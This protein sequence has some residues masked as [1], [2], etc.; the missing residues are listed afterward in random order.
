MPRPGRPLADLPPLPPGYALQG[1]QPAAP[2]AAALP[3]LPPGYQLQQPAPTPAKPPVKPQ[4]PSTAEEPQ[5]FADLFKAGAKAWGEGV[6]APLEAAAATVTGAVAKPVADIAG[7]AA[8]GVDLARGNKDGDPA[9]FQREVQERLTYAPRTDLGKATTE[10]IGQ[11]GD[12]TIGAAGRFSK[13]Y[14]GG[15]ARLL[16]APEA[17]SEAIGNAAEEATK[18][19]PNILGARVAGE[20]GAARAGAKAAAGP[21]G[22]AQAA[23]KAESYVRTRVG[24]DWNQ[25]PKA[26][27]DELTRIAKSSGD[28]EKLDPKAIERRAALQGLRIPVETTRAKLTRDAADLRREAVASKTDAGAPIRETDA[29]A[30]RDIQA[31]LEVLRG[32]KAGLRGGL[33]DPSEEGAP[34]TPSVRAPTKGTEDVGGSLQGSLRAKAAASKKNYDALYKKA[35]ETEP[36]ARGSVKPLDELLTRNPEIQHLGWVQGWLSKAAKAKQLATGAPEVTRL[37]DAS[38]AELHD[39]RS[40]ANEIAATGGKEGYY[41]KKVV[42]TIDGI[43]EQA[44]PAGA[45]AWKQANKAYRAHMEEFKDQGIIKKLVTNK[46]GDRALALEKTAQTI[47]KGSLEQIRQVKQSLL[48]AGEGKARFE[49]RQAW[50]DLQ[51][52]TVNRILEDARNVVATDET[53]RSVLTAAALRKGINSVG[54][55][56]L[57]EIIGKRSTDELYRILRAAKITRTEPAGRVTESGTVPNALVLAEKGL[58]HLIPGGKY[59]RG[60][61]EAIKTLGERGQAARDT[62]AAIKS[63]LQAAAEEAE[64]RAASRN[65]ARR[66]QLTTLGA[67]AGVTPREQ[68]PP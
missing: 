12:A 56:R 57:T 33:H 24:L 62:E 29:R 34:S 4:A 1:M 10:T 19:A 50:K 28:L 36:D 45:S 17:V 60:A 8:T 31:N 32:R 64:A 66:R 25:V 67:A 37:E 16:H 2:Q 44:T 7:L 48:T 26:L 58:A 52:E 5:T 14:Y 38:L 27:Q 47:A 42:K 55:D 40:D 59:I 35:R 15:A 51:G 6:A 39:L 68:P 65:A 3:P 30:N 22:A 23:A 49:G 63:P 18:Q 21:A 13:D 61:K 54:R 53:E 46:A 41:A 20:V 43:M 11:V 9:G